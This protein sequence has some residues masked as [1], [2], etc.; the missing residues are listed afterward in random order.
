MPRLLSRATLAGWVLA[1]ALLVSCDVRLP[2]QQA[3]CQRRQVRLLTPPTKPG[4]APDVL[5]WMLADR[6]HTSMIFPY[7]WLVE[8]GY[9]PPAG[10]G[11]PQYVV[12][13]WG[14]QIAYSK[15]GVDTPWR[16]LRVIF[17]PTPSVMELI[18]VEWNVAEV[19]SKQRIWRKLV[20]RTKG[21]ALAAFLNECSMTGPDGKPRVLCE[22]SWG[23]GVQLRGR[24]LYFIP[25]V[26]N[27]WTTQTI[28]NFGGKISPWFALTADGL[29]RQAERPPNDFE[30]IWAGSGKRP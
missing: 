21:P 15:R 6:Y 2:V 4:E 27:V 28:E 18:P 7:A 8:S 5:V 1:T 16:F 25:R 3:T 12:M 30:L 23:H 29:I 11:Q 9:I 26:C 14:S 20:T 17:T 13:S 19:C 22:S 10:F 24:Y